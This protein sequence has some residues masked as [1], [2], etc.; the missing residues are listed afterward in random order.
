MLALMRSA[1]FDGR[2]TV[3]TDAQI[4][5]NFVHAREA[6]MILVDGGLSLK[7]ESEKR[8]RCWS[9]PCNTATAGW[10]RTQGPRSFAPT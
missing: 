6:S 2:R 4:R 9:C 3:V 1:D 10:R 7:A 8:I 5:G